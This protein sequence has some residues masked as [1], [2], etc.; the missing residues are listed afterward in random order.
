MK[1]KMI[2]LLA[3]VFTLLNTTAQ[4]LNQGLIAHYPFDGNANDVSGYNNH[5]TVSGATLTAD[6]FGNPNS[7]YYFDG[8][9]QIDIANAVILNPTTGI[10]ISAWYKSV[11]FMGS[12]F[13]AIFAK[14]FTSHINPYYQYKIGVTGDQYAPPQFRFALTANGNVS[15]TATPANSWVPGNWYYLAGTFDGSVLRLYVNGVMTASVS[16]PGSISTYSTNVRFGN[17]TTAA[18]YITGTV[19]DTRIYDRA[20]TPAEVMALYC[21]PSAPITPL[22]YNSCAQSSDIYTISPVNGATSYTWTLPSGFTGT[23]LTNSITVQTGTGSGIVFVA[24][25][26]SC[27]TS[28][29]STF[30][31][32]IINCGTGISENNNSKFSWDVF[33]N[34]GQGDLLIRSDSEQTLQLRNELGQVLN[35]IEL[36]SANGHEL[37][38][39]GLP[40]GIYF[41]RGNS[42]VKKIVVIK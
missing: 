18:D 24:A 15:V 3:L 34:P 42:S 41:L 11:S 6:R 31:V 39:N 33:P 36:K 40:P 17:N 21:G 25:T 30:T 26:N 14:G 10:S 9:D 27:G 2:Y 37:Q 23:S 22:M 29:Y 13:S 4:N 32:N 12:G 8:N 20:L 35:Y 16:N 1:N 19:D 28:P 7:A 38:I 5:G